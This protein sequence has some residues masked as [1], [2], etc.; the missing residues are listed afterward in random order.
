MVCL[1]VTSS[2]TSSP[3]S[4]L[5]FK[6]KSRKRCPVICAWRNRCALF[7][8]SFLLEMQISQ[9]FFDWDLRSPSHFAHVR[10]GI[11]SSC[12]LLA[13]VEPALRDRVLVP[14]RSESRL[15]CTKL[16]K[17]LL[18]LL[19]TARRVGASWTYLFRLI[20][21]LSSSSSQSHETKCI[22]LVLVK[23]LSWGGGSFPL[24]RPRLRRWAEESTLF[25]SCV[26]EDD[27]RPRSGDAES[28]SEF[29]SEA[30]RSPS[31]DSVVGAFPL[32]PTR[33]LLVCALLE[34]W[35]VP[36]AAVLR[37]SLFF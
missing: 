8:F 28:I 4:T 16:N 2:S 24:Q 20:K 27:S 36:A 1:S 13:T 15:A 25:G 18:L 9:I 12:S 7:G 32:L 6:L 17:L 22:V 30:C 37:A 35:L 11:N 33:V 3:S 31:S 26:L 10:F 19:A 23:Q 14:P 21:Q 34:G 5:F 29:M